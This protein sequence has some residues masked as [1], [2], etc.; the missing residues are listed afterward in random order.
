MDR[1]ADPRAVAWLRRAVWAL[2]LAGFVAFLARGAD[3]PADP[4]LRAVPDPPPSAPVATTPRE[5]PKS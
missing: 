4:H 1:L 2:L 5:L 3:R